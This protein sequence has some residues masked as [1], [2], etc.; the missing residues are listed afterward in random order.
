MVI[1]TR[2]SQK[3][4]RGSN[5]Q[6]NAIIIVCSVLFSCILLITAYHVFKIGNRQQNPIYQP[7]ILN[8]IHTFPTKILDKDLSEAESTNATCNYFGCF[9]LYRCGSQGNKLSV[10]VYPPKIFLDHEDRPITSQMTKEF[11]QIL[12]AITSSKFYTPN[13]HEACIF[14]PSID[15]LNQNRLRLRQVSQALQSLEL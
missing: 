5:H 8:D 9:N 6:N 14:V 10:Y 7:L 11:Y 4:S 2:F 12:Y 1:V 15:T 13:P 3:L